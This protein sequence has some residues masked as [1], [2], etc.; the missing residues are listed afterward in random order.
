MLMKARDSQVSKLLV[1]N[2]KKNESIS[3]VVDP[4]KEAYL[5]RNKNQPVTWIL[6]DQDSSKWSPEEC[7]GCLVPLY[8]CT[9]PLTLF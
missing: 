8:S 7:W 9:S 2:E 6:N 1:S 5:V 4:E 3:R